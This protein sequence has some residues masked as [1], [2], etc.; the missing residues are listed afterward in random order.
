MSTLSREWSRAGSAVVNTT[1][2]KDAPQRCND[3]CPETSILLRRGDVSGFEAHKGDI[4]SCTS[5]A[6]WLTLSG[7][8]TDYVLHTGERFVA[9]QNGKVVIQALSADVLCVVHA[10]PRN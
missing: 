5:G 6:V 9:P 4:V 2:L 3:K 7:D 10:A 1:T 8:L